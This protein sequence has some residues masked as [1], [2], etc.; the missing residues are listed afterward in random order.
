MSGGCPQ[1]SILGV[2]LFNITTDDLEDDFL[3]SELH[4]DDDWAPLPEQDVG[5]GNALDTAATPSPDRSPSAAS[6]PIRVAPR[7]S[8]SEV[9]FHTGQPFVFVGVARNV[10]DPPGKATSMVETPEEPNH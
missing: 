4:V 7:L 5:N 2:F 10:G 6:T 3:H 8:D 9:H 1:G